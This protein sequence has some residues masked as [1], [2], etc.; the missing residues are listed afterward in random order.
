MF[1]KQ[2]IYTIKLTENCEFL[3]DSLAKTN[4]KERSPI[5]PNDTHLALFFEK[6]SGAPLAL[7]IKIALL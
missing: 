6:L 4:E 5:F 1:E 2:R 3:K 7:S